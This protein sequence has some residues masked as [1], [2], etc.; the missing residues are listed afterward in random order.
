MPETHD[1]AS[2][3]T[4]VDAVRRAIREGRATIE[5]TPAIRVHVTTDDGHSAHFSTSEDEDSLASPNY[6]I[7]PDSLWCEDLDTDLAAT[8]GEAFHR[9]IA[10]GLARVTPAPVEVGAIKG[11]SYDQAAEF[12]TIEC[13]HA[14]VTVTRGA[15][16]F[17]AVRWVNGRAE[18]LD[19]DDG[20]ALFE[21]AIERWDAA[22]EEKHGERAA[23]DTP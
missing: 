20:R 21:R 5:I 7:D 18:Q 13:E 17:E 14:T 15:E 22:E 10:A 2:D 8:I 3:D 4:A 1:E 16:T 12:W 23:S 6:V 19:R 9:E 11:V